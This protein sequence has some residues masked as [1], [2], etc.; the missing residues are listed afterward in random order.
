MMMKYSKLSNEDEAT[1]VVQSKFSFISFRAK[2]FM[3]RRASLISYETR[4]AVT[5]AKEKWNSFQ[6][7]IRDSGRSF[8]RNLEDT[9]T[10]TEDDTINITEN[11]SLMGTL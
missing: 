7:W 4:R 10:L 11:V 5:N 9:I 3:Q 2:M 6:Y 1:A 8:Q